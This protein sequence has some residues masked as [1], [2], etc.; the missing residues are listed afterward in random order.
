MPST[1]NALAPVASD[2]N[3]I[4]DAVAAEMPA[5]DAATAVGYGDRP[6]PRQQLRLISWK[7]IVRGAL[8][9][10]ATVELPIGLRIIDI[11]V[12]IGANG[13]WATLPSKPELDGEGHR[14][15]DVIGKPTW[16]P[17]LEWRTRELRDRFA[18]SVIALVRQA[19]LG[20]L[21]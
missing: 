16:A 17:V 10:F 15:T 6:A 14:K 4:L 5:V 13:A 3:S 18:D 2:A 21:A 9:E 7:P 12:L 11:P 8:R 19:H 1:Q 20:D